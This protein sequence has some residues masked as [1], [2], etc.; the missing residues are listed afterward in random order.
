MVFY[1]VEQAATFSYLIRMESIILYAM[2]P[3]EFI[4]NILAISPY[5]TNKGIISKPSKLDKLYVCIHVIITT[6]A[7][8]LTLCGRIL[9]HYV[10]VHHIPMASKILDCLSL[11]VPTVLITST[12]WFSTN[13]HTVLMNLFFEKLNKATK[14]ANFPKAIYIELKRK[15][16]KQ[17]FV[18]LI[19]SPVLAVI[20]IWSWSHINKDVHLYVYNYWLNFYIFVIFLQV[21]TKVTLLRQ[22][23]ISLNKTL[24]RKLFEV[25]QKKEMFSVGKEL[26]KLNY[27]KRY[28]L[29]AIIETYYLLCDL[30]QIIN[31]MHGLQILL[32]VGSIILSAVHLLHFGI[33]IIHLIQYNPHFKNAKL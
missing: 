14:K 4:S 25:C 7:M 15:I 8:T 3:L 22:L 6:A 19:G 1:L 31:D 33:S 20:N 29:I 27:F 28:N 21:N 17:C 18:V 2:K 24:K 11:I 16:L 13:K 9:Y 23:F 5:K 12:M 10:R 32:I 30:L 26:L